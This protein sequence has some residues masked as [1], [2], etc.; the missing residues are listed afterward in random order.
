MTALADRRD[1]F[2]LFGVTIL[3]GVL[4]LYAL[5]DK[6]LANDEATSYFIAQLDWSPLW[7][8]LATSE[9]NAS[10]FYVS[11]KG[12]LGLGDSEFVL[13]L[14]PALFA[15]VSS[16]ALYLLA[17]RLFGSIRAVAASALMS[18]NVLFVS[19]AQEVRGYSLSVM[20]ATLSTLFFVKAV[21]DKTTWTFVA[22]ALVG[23]LSLYAHFFAAFVLTAHLLSLLFLK[24]DQIPIRG[25]ATSYVGIALL[26]APLA[27]FILFRNVG[28]VDWIPEPSVGQ[29][30]TALVQLTG[31]GGN[32]MLVAYGVLTG[33]TL[34]GAVFGLSTKR[35]DVGLW[36]CGLSFLWLSIPIIGGFALS[37]VQPVFQSRYLLVA[38]PG[39]ALCAVLGL[40]VLR[41]APVAIA[42]FAVLAVLTA[43]NLDEWYSAGSTDNWRAK[44]EIVLDNARSGDGIVFYSPTILRPFG[45]YAGYYTDEESSPPTLPRILYPGDQWLGYSKTRFSPAYGRIVAESARHARVWLV[46]GYTS[47]APRRRE[48]AELQSSLRQAC[49]LPVETFER[50]TVK[51]YADCRALSG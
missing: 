3:A 2:G 24:R 14:L 26:A 42:A 5:G 17:R 51:L 35:G 45:Y 39:V 30:H 15:V 31:N 36:G 47:D 16:P 41:P 32:G 28:Q 12:W 10:L 1:I 37:Y 27:Y 25:L 23:G 9:A 21:L 7:E 11:L 40:S 18:V 29:L 20:L 6:D 4:V 50:G 46:T 19:H 44:T 22:Y 38:V 8:S 33:V 43:M 49:G 48:K 34:I 13:R